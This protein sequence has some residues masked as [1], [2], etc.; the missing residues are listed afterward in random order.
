LEPQRRPRVVMLVGNF[1]DGDS[2]VQKEARSAAA[3]GWDAYLIGRSPTGRREEYAL[4]AATV[5]RAAEGMA[6]TNYRSA[7]PRRIRRGFSGIVAYKSLDLSKVRHQRQR[8]RQRELDVEQELLKRKLADGANPVSAAAAKAAFTAHSANV[9]ARG[10]WIAARKQAFD[11]NYQAFRAEPTTAFQMFRAKR[12]SEAANWAIQPR[13]VDFEDAFSRECDELQPDLIHANDADML[14]IAVRCAARARKAGRTV[15]VV[16]DAHEYFAGEVR[17]GDVSWTA[18]MAAQEA[19]YLPL[20]DG[21]SVAAESFVEALTERYGLPVP[22]TVVSNMPG[23]TPPITEVDR[24]GGV[25]A[26]I[27]LAPDVPLLVHAGAVTPVRGIDTVVRALV[28]LE[29]AGV[30]FVLVAGNRDGHVADLVKLAESLGC[31]DRFHVTDYVAQE[32]LT[33]FLASAD[34]GV[35]PLTHTPHHE[36]TVTTKF[37]SYVSAR[38]PMLVSDVQEMAKLAR[39][40]G[41]GEVFVAQDADSAA[42]AVRKL[43]AG[44]DHYVE[45]YSDEKLRRYTWEDQAA[46]LLGLYTRVT[47][48]T[49]VEI[50]VETDRGDADLTTE[51]GG[52]DV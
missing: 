2:R 26:A 20:V 29:D 40:I 49:P 34:I 17:Q 42:A 36:L 50:E 51:N 7:H 24:K 28:Q 4:G 41:G 12:G 32:K 8:L 19:R 22:P 23:R 47:G 11:R 33:K 39:E 13:L 3:A 37:W 48:L 44:R 52:D 1:I 35:E 38:L 46:A 10:Y 45:A 14:G 6:A 21:V 27:G 5:I 30:H 25:R 18:V 15:K 43:I 31:G 9:R 16:Y